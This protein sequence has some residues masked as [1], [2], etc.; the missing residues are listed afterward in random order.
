MIHCSA[1]SGQCYCAL[2]QGVSACTTV[3]TVHLQS[4]GWAV[5][6]MRF[7]NAVT[8]GGSVNF[9]TSG[10]NFSRNN[11]IYDINESTKYILS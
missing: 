5:S 9:F 1:I 4:S 2:V 11:T 6:E 7:V 3:C 8:A 10:V